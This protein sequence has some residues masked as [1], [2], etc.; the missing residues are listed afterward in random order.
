MNPIKDYIKW[1]K[2]SNIYGQSGQKSATD[3]GEVGRFQ[4]IL[5]AKWAEISRQY[6]KWA[7][8][9]QFLWAKWAE[10]SRP[11]GQSGHF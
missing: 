9:Q 1:A 5:W 3:M 4:Q 11:Y 10:I 8:S 6:S 2:I 7:K